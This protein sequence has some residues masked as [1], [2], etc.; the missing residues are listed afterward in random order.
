VLKLVAGLA[1]FGAKL[2]R[3]LGYCHDTQSGIVM[4]IVDHDD[5]IL[6]IMTIP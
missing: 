1:I 3:L 4:I 2:I 5:T 6:W